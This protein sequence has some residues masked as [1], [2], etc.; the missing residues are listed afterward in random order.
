MLDIDSL[1]GNRARVRLTFHHACE[2]KD[3][4]REVLMPVQVARNDSFTQSCGADGLTV[5][6]T[7]AVVDQYAELVA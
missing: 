7:V 4:S 3:Y 2:H 1:S 6:V 5:L